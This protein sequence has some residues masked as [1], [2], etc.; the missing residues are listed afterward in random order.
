MPWGWGYWP[1]GWKQEAPGLR[2]EAG[3]LLGGMAS[4]LHWASTPRAPPPHLIFWLGQDILQDLSSP[5]RIERMP[6]LVKV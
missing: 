4:L 3:D 2:R 5:A 1:G 6:L